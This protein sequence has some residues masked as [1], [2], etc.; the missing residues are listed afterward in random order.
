MSSCRSQPQRTLYLAFG[1][2]EEVGGDL[3]AGAMATLLE[4]RGVTLDF[5]VDEGGP[6]LVDGLPSLLRSPAQIALIGTA[7]KVRMGICTGR[8]KPMPPPSFPALHFLDCMRCTHS[9][10]L[11]CVT[12]LCDL[13]LARS[14]AAGRKLSKA[15]W[16]AGTVSQ[17]CL[18][19][20]FSAGHVT[21]A[22]HPHHLVAISAAPPK[23][24]A[25]DFFGNTSN[26][27]LVML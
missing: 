27:C 20:I 24:L 22:Q 19:F 5:V 7:E 11:F 16:Q 2:D 15:C 6:V 23:H 12:L 26:V 8:K 25:A 10:F 3:G 13:L 17:G 4:S 14:Q 1:H 21:M 9:A 18:L